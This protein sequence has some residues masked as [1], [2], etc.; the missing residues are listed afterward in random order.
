MSEMAILAENRRKHNN[1]SSRCARTI[2]N[3]GLELETSRN[4]RN[5]S[6]LQLLCRY[7]S[8]KA[9]ANNGDG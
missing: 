8:C 6:E 5:Q 1:N 3:L 4:S 2:E 9:V 7:N